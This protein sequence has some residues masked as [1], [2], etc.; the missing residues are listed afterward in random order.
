VDPK[1]ARMPFIFFN[2]ILDNVAKMSDVE[3]KRIED[4][5][6]DKVYMYI[7]MYVCM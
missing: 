4:L 5:R 1:K 3:K 6:R 7:Y 2:N